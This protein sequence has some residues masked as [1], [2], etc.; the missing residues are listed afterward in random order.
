MPMVVDRPALVTLEKPLT[1]MGGFELAFEQHLCHLFSGY[2]VDEHNA[3]CVD[4]CRCGRHLLVAL[5]PGHPMTTYA[6]EERC[7]CGNPICPECRALAA[8]D[9]DFVP[10]PEVEE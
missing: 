7:A 2:V 8:E 1:D 5:Y 6:G 9:R 4:R 10:L 3:T